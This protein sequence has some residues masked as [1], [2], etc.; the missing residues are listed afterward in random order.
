MIATFCHK[1]Y[2]A[3]CFGRLSYLKQQCKEITPEPLE[4]YL[5]VCTFRA[6]Y[7]AFDLFKFQQG[8]FTGVH[9]VIEVLYISNYM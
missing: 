2:F 6:I 3:D 8:E 4:S 5:S 7:A 9:D 1:L